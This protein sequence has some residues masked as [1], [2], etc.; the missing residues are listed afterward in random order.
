MIVHS[1]LAFS[2]RHKFCRGRILVLINCNDF[3]KAGI[4]IPLLCFSERK[5]YRQHSDKIHA[6]TKKN[7]ELDFINIKLYLILTLF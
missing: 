5:G 4:A 6:K 7:K 2:H 3:Y 1:D